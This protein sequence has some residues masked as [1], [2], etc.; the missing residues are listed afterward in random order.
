[1]GSYRLR[2]ERERL[3]MA[4]FGGTLYWGL[5]RRRERN[6]EERVKG[7]GRLTRPQC[8]RRDFRDVGDK[9]TTARLG[10]LADFGFEGG[11]G[12]LR[13]GFCG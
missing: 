5:E 3:G 9:V 2:R 11:V 6:A 12:Y 7:K 13:R 8:L 1:M 10:D 4:V